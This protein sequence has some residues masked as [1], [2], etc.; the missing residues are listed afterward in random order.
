M[1]LI[2]AKLYEEYIRK[3]DSAKFNITLY[4]S[5]VYLFLIF[6]LILPVKTFIDKKIYTDQIH[7]EKSTIMTVFLGLLAFITYWVYYFYIKKNYIETLTMRYKKIKLNKTVLYL[8][9]VLTP[10]TL[11]LFAGIIMVFLNGGEIFGNKINGLLE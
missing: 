8:I 11:L 4:I 7:Y 3:N 5:I 1:N 10:V 6:V 9:V 2:F